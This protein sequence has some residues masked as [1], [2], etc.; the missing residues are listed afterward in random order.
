MFVRHPHGAVFPV[1]LALTLSAVSCGTVA[2]APETVETQDVA[3]SEP[4]APT[5]TRGEETEARCDRPIPI[6]DGGNVAGEVC[7]ENAAARGLTAI[8]LSGDW[9]PL[10]FRQDPAVT[11]R[12]PYRNAYLALADERLRELP[13]NV[14]RE[15][16][17]ELYGIFPTFRVLAERLED[18]ERHA[19]H[20]AIDDTALGE[21][22]GVMRPWGEMADT[23]RRRATNL[24]HL[25]TRLERARV[26][27]GL[28]SIADLAADPEFGRMYAQYDQH[29]KPFEAI[30]ATQAHL[31]CDGLLRGRYREGAFDWQTSAAL[32]EFQ[33]MHMVVGAGFLDD[34]TREALALDSREAD[35]RA[36]LRTLRER[37]VSAT[38][39]LEDGSAARSWGTVLGRQLDPPE[40]RAEVGQPAAPDPAPDLV[41]PATE[42]AARA[43][44]WTDPAAAQA[45]FARPDLPLSV[46]IRLPPLPAYHSSHM[47]LRAEIDRG[48]VWYEFGSRGR[49]PERRPILTLYVRHEGREIALVR[50]STTIGGWKPE[51]REDGTVGLKYKNS[52]AGERIWRDVIASP[53]WLPPVGTP[54]SDLVRNGRPN[55]SILGP[56]YRS[57]YGLA[58]VM[59]HRVMEPS[60]EGEETT[61]LD[62]GIRAHGSVSYRSIIQGTSHGCHRLYNHLA[63]R[64]TSFLISHRN[65][66]T[67]GHLPASWR[68]T[69]VLE[70]GANA[71]FEVRSRGYLF[72]LTPPIQVNVLD[73]NI[74]GPLSNPPMG[75]RELPEAQ[76]AEARAEAAANEGD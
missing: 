55:H 35:F 24:Q 69:V 33:R 65:H 32:R 51:T 53:A 61:F 22:S 19:C 44:G 30:V 56:G 68:R 12:Q 16:Y 57:A 49:Q 48:D 34:P 40:V 45:Y 31:V 28:A 26:A 38:G 71:E 8:D 23:Q 11:S 25:R 59:H 70:D 36:V 39:L 17:L 41:S 52:P 15:K 29:R 27:K 75:F 58:M 21:I 63:V 67:R 42:A 64:L 60:D 73:G 20:E 66:S 46:A 7:A 2:E 74:R 43:L 54:D 1:L 3:T 76:V 9:T 4:E 5:T 47:D 18:A 50:W 72:E 10:V 37:V 62:E 14:P 6:V 13:R